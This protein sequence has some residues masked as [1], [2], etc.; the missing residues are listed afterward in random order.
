MKTKEEKFNLI[1]NQCRKDSNI[2]AL[3][4][5]GSRGKSPEL[6]T[7]FSDY[8]VF[9][10]TKGHAVKMYRKKYAVLE[11]EG[12][13][14]LIMS[15]SELKRESEDWN[16][17]NYAYVKPIF[18]K[19][20]TI[21]EVIEKKAKIP[22]PLVKKYISGHLDGYINYVYRSF[23]CWRDNNK[24]GARL[25]ANRSLDIFLMVIFA[26]HQRRSTP[27]YKYLEWELKNHPLTEINLSRTQVLNNLQKI[28]NTGDISA[29]KELFNSLERLARKEGYGNVFDKWRH[30][31]EFIKNFT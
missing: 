6:V 14:F 27:Y 20:N 9:V 19:T 7:E 24:L 16:R 12:F 30:K 2:L 10:I 25:E 15:L 18:D 8:D 17:Y 11:N 26:L 21:K 22:T 5:G 23:K 28:I 29:Q 31:L 4:L 3:F 13:D 1:V